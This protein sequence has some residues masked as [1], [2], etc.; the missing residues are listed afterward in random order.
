MEANIS[1]WFWPLPPSSPDRPH[2]R[3]PRRLCA[4][5]QSLSG[6]PRVA[7]GPWPNNVA[8][9]N[10]GLPLSV[11]P[12]AQSPHAYR[13]LPAFLRMRPFACTQSSAAVPRLTQHHPR[14]SARSVRVSTSIRYQFS[15]LP[16]CLREPLTSLAT[17]P[18]LDLGSAPSPCKLVEVLKA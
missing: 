14:P 16:R 9:T 6:R 1:R 5:R 4:C 18:L 2:A 17:L 7:M 13:L 12:T 11:I 10:L 3:L 15:L 8:T